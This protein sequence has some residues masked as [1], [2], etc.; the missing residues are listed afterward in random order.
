QSWT[1]LVCYSQLETKLAE[2]DKKVK[3]KPED[4]D[5]LAERGDYLL[6]KGDLGSAI[7]DFRAALAALEKNPDPAL[8]ART[9]TKLYEAMTELFQRD[10]GEAEKNIKEYEKLCKMDTDGKTGSEL[11]QLQA[12]ERRR[13]ANFLFL[14]GK[15]REAQGRLAEAFDRYL[16]LGLEAKKDELIQVVDE[17]SVKA[18]PDVWAQGRIRSMVDNCKDD[19]KRKELES[20]IAGRWKKLK[21]TASSLDELRK[22]VSLFGSMFGVGKE[23]RLALAER[24]MKNT[25]INSLLEAEQQLSMLRN[26]EEKPEIAAR[27]VEALARL[28]EGKG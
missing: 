7:T 3:A 25:D 13:R 15:G 20:R 26:E 24:L 9:R 10:F 8:K 19:K 16:E 27:A 14:V 11:S 28:N 17:P 22:F 1:G 4:P 18:A 12:E 2:M 6:D 21:G 23:A 5:L